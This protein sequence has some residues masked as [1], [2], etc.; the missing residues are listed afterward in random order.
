MLEI[1]TVIMLSVN[2]FLR[3]KSYVPYPMLSLIA[4]DIPSI[5]AIVFSA[6]FVTKKEISTLFSLSGFEQRQKDKKTLSSSDWMVVERWRCNA[7]AYLHS[8]IFKQLLLRRRRLIGTTPSSKAYK[9]KWPNSSTANPNY[10]VENKLSDLELTD[11]T[12]VSNQTQNT[13]VVQ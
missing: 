2:R 5:D 11:I 12:L 7:A 10:K 6:F 13:N 4:V 9:L 8:C 1:N 3:K